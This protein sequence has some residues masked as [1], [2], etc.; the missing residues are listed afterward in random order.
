MNSE[1]KNF[2]VDVGVVLLVLMVII[3]FAALSENFIKKENGCFDEKEI[4][5]TK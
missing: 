3:L 5:R 1:N 2:L 4:T